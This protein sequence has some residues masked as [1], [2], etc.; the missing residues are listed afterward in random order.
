MCYDSIKVGQASCLYRTGASH[1]CKL[2]VGWRS[3]CGA[4]DVSLPSPIPR[5]IS[6]PTTVFFGKFEMLPYR[7]GSKPV[8]LGIKNRHILK[9]G[10]MTGLAYPTVVYGDV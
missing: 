9:I 2:V 1:F 5:D 10:S 6:A 3:L 4:S 7:T 8:A